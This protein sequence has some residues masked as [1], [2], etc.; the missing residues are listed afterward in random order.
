MSNGNWIAMFKK[1][2]DFNELFMSR[3]PSREEKESR[4]ATLLDI[5]NCLIA[6]NVT[7][8]DYEAQLLRLRALLDEFVT[9]NA[10][11]PELQEN[12]QTYDVKFDNFILQMK[13]VILTVRVQ[14]MLLELCEM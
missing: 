11:H 9:L 5:R 10:H 8:V 2:T 3:I 12:Y 13:H 4:E 1:M 7:R 6:E 14:I